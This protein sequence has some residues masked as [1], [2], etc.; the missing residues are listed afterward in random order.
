M[1]LRPLTVLAVFLFLG[2]VGFAQT[3]DTDRIEYR[4]VDLKK[5]TIQMHWKDAKDSIIGSLAGLAD[6]YTTSPEKLLY[7]V[8]GG[9]FEPGQIPTG[10]YIEAGKSLNPLNTAN[11]RGNF[12]LKPNG[13]FAVFKNNTVAVI[14]TDDFVADDQILFATQSGPMLLI[15]GAFHPAFNKGSEN[16]RIRN[17]VGILPDGNVILAKSKEIINFY[18]FASFFK[19]MGCKNALYL[20]G[21]I[22]KTYD[23]VKGQAPSIQEF[24][25]MIAITHK[26]PQ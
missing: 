18:D 23:S 11:G 13:V 6:I 1:R 9:I 4:I 2:H 10:L 16:M 26:K 25:V 17:G 8:N 20:D 14:S 5:E 7:A 3:I 19:E 22:S 15:D 24:T 21:G 12:F